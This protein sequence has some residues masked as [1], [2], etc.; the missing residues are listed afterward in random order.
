MKAQN[1][2]LATAQDGVMYDR[3]FTARI[4]QADE[5]VRK[6]YHE[7]KAELVSYK[8]VKSR[9]SWTA[10]SFNKGRN[11]CAKMQ[12]KGK[13]LVLYLALDP[14]EVASKYHTQSVS[15]VAKYAA[16]PTKLRI[17]NPRS[18]KYAKELIAQLMEKTGIA[19]AAHAPAAVEIPVQTTEELLAAGLVKSKK[20]IRPA[21]WGKV[22]E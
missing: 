10:D 1:T 5:T 21:F 3:S 6:Y 17:R 11:K 7:I 4:A 14:E 22:G 9:I 19:K 13:T 12:I 2:E 20:G 8:G 15:G 18:L 16:V